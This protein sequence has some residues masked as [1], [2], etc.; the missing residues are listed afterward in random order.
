LRGLGRIE[1]RADVLNALNDRAEEGLG[2]DNLFAPSFGR[3]TVF[4][5]PRRVMVSASVNLGR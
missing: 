5:D 2:T 1:L 3:A 4:M